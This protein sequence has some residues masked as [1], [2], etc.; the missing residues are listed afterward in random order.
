MKLFKDKGGCR[1]WVSRL[2][3]LLESLTKVNCSKV[4]VMIMDGRHIRVPVLALKMEFLEDECL[5]NLSVLPCGLVEIDRRLRCVCCIQHQGGED[6]LR[7]GGC[8]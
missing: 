3:V 6:C 5:L 1:R 2:R 8:F 7:M 4:N